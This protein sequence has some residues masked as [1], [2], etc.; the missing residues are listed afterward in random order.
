MTR[1]KEENQAPCPVCMEVLKVQDI[2]AHTQSH[3]DSSDVSA[4][5]DVF[6][7]DDGDSGDKVPCPLGCGQHLS[8]KQVPS[9]EAA[10]RSPRIISPPCPPNICAMQRPATFLKVTPGIIQLLAEALNSQQGRFRAALSGPLHHFSATPVD[11]DWACG[12]R[13]I[14]MLSSHLLMRNEG[15]SNAM[16][17]G[18]GYT[19]D[20]ISMQAWLE[21]AWQSGFDT[22]GAEQLGHHV[23]GTQKW[24]GTTE[25]AALLRQFGVRALVIDFKGGERCSSRHQREARP[26]R[27]GN[28]LKAAREW[29]PI[30]NGVQ[31][32]RCGVCPIQ[33]PRYNSQILREYNLCG[34]CWALDG[35][36][37]IGPFTELQ[38][39][40]HNALFDYVWQYFTGERAGQQ[41]KGC[42]PGGQRQS[43][44][45]PVI[46]SNKP[47]LYFQHE[48]HSRTIV[49]IER[50]EA[51]EG[52]A[53]QMYLLILD[54]S[55]GTAQIES[56]LRS[57]RGWQR[58][59]KRSLC[60]LQKPEYQLLIC[61]D[62]LA[63]GQALEDLKIMRASEQYGF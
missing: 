57:R 31:C 29:A 5:P 51:G 60:W 58:L 52:M 9:H 45:G 32:D 21:C 27:A 42:E 62:G 28:R 53:P 11:A 24:V 48:G 26:S 54:P 41:H 10:H 39:V 61:P 50:H 3:L 46:M 4:E 35:M 37:A 16:Y 6:H 7:G 47:P 63:S 43:G 20:V 30:H 13:N 2:E 33:G 34:K 22:E 49:G 59:I 1:E 55:Q 12:W 25:A 18:C 23:Q 17:C 56:A 8:R 19:P 44:S 14:Q 15:L 36:D 40:H 38:E